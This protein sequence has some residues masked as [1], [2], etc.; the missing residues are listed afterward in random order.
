MFDLQPIFVTGRISDHNL[1]WLQHQRDMSINEQTWH[2]DQKSLDHDDNTS[3]LSSQLGLVLHRRV[4]EGRSVKGI[5]MRTIRIIFAFLALAIPVTLFGQIR[6]SISI[7]PPA[8]PEYAQ[9]ICPGDGY[10][11]TPGYWAYDDSVSDYYWV[12]GE[13]V[14]APEEGFLWTPGYW[15]WGDGGYRFNEGY[16]GPEVGFYGGINYG[17]GYSGNG[18]EGGRWDSGHFF[19]NRSENNVDVSRNRNVYD[20]PI[21]NRNDSRVSF[22]GGSGGIEVRATSQQEAISRQRH[23]APVG[24]Q[25]QHAQTARANPELRAASNHGKPAIATATRPE[26]VNERQGIQPGAK[27]SDN[28]QPRTA[29]HPNDLAPIARPEPINSGNAKAD[30]KYQKQ[31]GALINKQ[32]Q[33][34]Q[35]LQVKQD[36]EHQ[37]MSQQKA[38]DSR[39]QQVEQKHQQQTQQMSNKHEAQQ[40]SLQ[41]HQPQAKEQKK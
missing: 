28:A 26:A 10:L 6:I 13:W 21:S 16:W 20:A 9:P 17:N 15:G 34:R 7:G 32:N 35:S 36:S 19:Y 23:V 40:Q 31:Q 2:V 38:N 14:M 27:P 41:A 8:L 30:Q 5:F 1:N 4:I 29:Y 24:A 25:T 3:C 18:Y 12:G 11:W 39:T 22:N 33:E 37:R